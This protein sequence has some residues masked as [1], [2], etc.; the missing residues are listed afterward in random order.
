MRASK[1]SFMFLSVGLC[2]RQP[3]LSEKRQSRIQNCLRKW[4][5]SGVC[6]G[7]F[8][9]GF[10]SFMVRLKGSGNVLEDILKHIANFKSLFEQKLIPVGQRQ[11]GS[12]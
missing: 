12:G 6:I 8:Q 4:E 2:S 9:L 7:K 1:E 3:C 5:I 10:S 11:T